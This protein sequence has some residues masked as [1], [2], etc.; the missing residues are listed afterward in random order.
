MLQK[1]SLRVHVLAS[2]DK[3]KT[4]WHGCKNLFFY[5]RIFGEKCQQFLTLVH[6]FQF[7]EYRHKMAFV[8]LIYLINQFIGTPESMCETIDK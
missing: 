2:N 7:Y 1:E 3:L 4:E 6:F 8:Y 5:S